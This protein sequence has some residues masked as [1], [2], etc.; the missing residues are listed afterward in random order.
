M[1]VLAENKDK[2]IFALILLLFLLF[3]LPGLGN[4]LSNTDALRWHRRSEIFLTAIKS[5]DLKETYRHYQPG[6][7]IMWV[8]SA[9]KQVAFSTQH[10]VLKIEEPKTLENADYYPAIHGVSKAVLV[11]ILCS[12]LAIQ[13]LFLQKIFGDKIAFIFGFLMAIEPYMIGMDRWFH[14]TSLETYFAFLSFLALL[15]W[16][17]ENRDKLLVFS[18]LFS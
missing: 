2:K 14:L 17:K 18:G 5:G 11:F 9:V 7:T 16:K 8:N 13:I 3:R 15:V 1:K 6:M 4:D 12:L 10:R